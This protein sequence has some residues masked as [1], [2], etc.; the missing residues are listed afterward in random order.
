M[1]NIYDFLERLETHLNEKA[2]KDFWIYSSRAYFGALLIKSSEN[3]KRFIFKPSDSS[4]PIGGKRIQDYIVKTPTFRGYK[5]NNYIFVANSF[6]DIAKRIAK[7]N[8]QITLLSV[9]IRQKKVMLNGSMN[10]EVNL[11]NQIIEFAN[12]VQYEISYDFEGLLKHQ[13]FDKKQEKTITQIEQR[14]INPIVFFSYSWDSDEHRFWVLKLASELIKNGI[15]VMID[16]W[17]LEKHNNDLHV[18][19]E[20][21]I[22]NSDKVIMICTKNYMQKTNNRQGGVGVENTIITGEI[23]DKSKENKFIPIV[24]EYDT[25]ITDSLPSYLK[26]KF[27]I[28]FSKEGE[29]RSKFE[30]LLRK[31]LNVP[32]YKKPELGKLVNLK[33]NEIS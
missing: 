17:D 12:S 6:K 25:K 7:A 20:T 31:I 21:G 11:L 29:F 5:I 28:D 18:F 19:M 4:L 27:T 13:G 22:R 26:T 16:E 3:N 10:I 24:R 32:K 1:R 14:T 15:D 30:E 23:Y 33:S 2:K 9:D 8:K